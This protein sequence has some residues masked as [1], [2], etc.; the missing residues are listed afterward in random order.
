MLSLTQFSILNESF[1]SSGQKQ[2]PQNVQAPQSS[3]PAGAGLDDN[4]QEATRPSQT[5]RQSITDETVENGE[6]AGHRPAKKLAD[7]RRYSRK[8]VL[9]AI[10]HLP[11][12]F[13]PYRTTPHE[14]GN[15]GGVGTESEKRLA[16]PSYWGMV[17]KI[18]AAAVSRIKLKKAGNHRLVDLHY[19]GIVCDNGDQF[20]G[21]VFQSAKKIAMPKPDEEK[22]TNKMR[23]NSKTQQQ[24]NAKALNL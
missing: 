2:Q 12:A 8:A 23:A 18:V 16:R 22:G 20:G 4:P 15:Y 19:P 21:E 3:S 6:Q 10:C 1:V 7:N 9:L 11:S 14:T 24:R 5:G 13:N 17:N